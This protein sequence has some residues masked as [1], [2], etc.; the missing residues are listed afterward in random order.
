MIGRCPE[1]RDEEGLEARVELVFTEVLMVSQPS[2]RSEH[3]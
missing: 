2:R 3:S 1:R